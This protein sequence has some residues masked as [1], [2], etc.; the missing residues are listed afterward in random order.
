MQDNMIDVTIVCHTYNH[1]KYI[2]ECLDG[3]LMQKVDFNYEVVIHDDAS[4]DSTAEI[5]RDYAAKYPEIFRPIYQKE[6]KYSQGIQITPQYV[7][8]MIRGRYVA[9]CEGDDKWIDKNKL[10]IQYDYLEKHQDCSMCVHN[11]VMNN[12]Y[13][14]SKKLVVNS[15]RDRDYSLSKVVYGGGG[16]FATN[17]I[18]VR[19]DIYMNRP[20]CFLCKGCGDYQIVIYAAISGRVHYINRVMSQYNYGTEESW[21]RRVENDVSKLVVHRFNLIEMLN[22]VDRYY[23]YKYTKILKR[24]MSNL[25]LENYL[26]ENNKEMLRKVE[27]RILYWKRWI[28]RK[29]S[30]INRF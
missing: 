13:T 6:N 5:I 15:K 21:S 26:A 27:Y 12:L 30:V 28:G 29:L 16:L 3:F 17:S 7:Y 19:K 1:E 2:R 8:P 20:E 4:T 22:R 24:E 18:F 11:T 10:Q 25:K 9:L 23:E 14:N